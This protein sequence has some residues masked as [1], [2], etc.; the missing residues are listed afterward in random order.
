[1]GAGDEEGAGGKGRFLMPEEARRLWEKYYVLTL[2]M[3]KFLDRENIDVFLEV[4]GQRNVIF[5]RM[6]EATTEAHKASDEYKAF[7]ARLRPVAEDVGRRARIW[8]ARSKKRNAEVRA[9][10]APGFQPAGHMVNTKS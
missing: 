9:Y 10:G 2:E 5:D 7:L 8:L 1:M 3:Q 6:Q 4:A